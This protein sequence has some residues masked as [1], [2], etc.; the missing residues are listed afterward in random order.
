MEAEDREGPNMVEALMFLAQHYKAHNRYEK[1]EVYCTRLL[2][3]TG[4]ERETAKSLLRGMR[5]D[6]SGFASMHVERFLP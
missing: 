1:S 3:Y 5:M 4:P 6:Q 2:D